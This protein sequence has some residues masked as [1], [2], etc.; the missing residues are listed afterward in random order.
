MKYQNLKI[1][2][3]IKQ[4][5]VTNSKFRFYSIAFAIVW[6]GGIVKS[7]SQS[8]QLKLEVKFLQN[9]LDLGIISPQEYANR[10][11]HQEQRFKTNTSA[12]DYCRNL[13]VPQWFEDQILS[14]RL[15]AIKDINT[16]SA[17]LSQSSQSNY[18]SLIQSKIDAYRAQDLSR[19]DYLIKNYCFLVVC[20]FFSMF[21]PLPLCVGFVFCICSVS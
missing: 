6:F 19:K 11:Q 15:P 18:N 21:L 3:I 9:D 2:Y 7:Y 12:A 4:Y 13:Q 16:S 5:V 8:N 14:H 10:V 17:Y 1:I 20:V